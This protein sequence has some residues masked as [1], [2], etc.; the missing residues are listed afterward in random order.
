MVLMR[1]LRVSSMEVTTKKRVIL[2]T[3]GGTADLEKNHRITFLL[4][5]ISSFAEVLMM[6]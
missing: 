5:I 3:K 2:L 4:N 1:R 6:K